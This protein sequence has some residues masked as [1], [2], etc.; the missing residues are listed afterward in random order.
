MASALAGLSEGAALISARDGTVR[1][2]NAALEVLLERPDL[3]GLP[4][5]SLWTLPV[6]LSREESS[7]W[8]GPVEAVCGDG[9]REL[10]AVLIPLGAGTGE[11]GWLALLTDEDSP[12]VDGT[13][14]DRTWETDVARAMARARRS[15]GELSVAIVS[16]D[17]GDTETLEA[18]AIA[19]ASALRAVDAIAHYGPDRVVVIL[20]GCAMD[21]ALEV[22]ARMRAATPA[23]GSSSAGIG[24]WDHEESPASLCA[25]ASEALDRAR[26]QG[27][28]LAV[29]APKPS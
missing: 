25:R 12:G 21:Q 7:A 10:R 8:S 29:F 19:W 11:G 24:Y 14:R 5:A 23:P 1:F 17:Q 15:G 2:V 9:H 20:A 16:L 18:A 4:V 6:D 13:S 27:P 28:G 22:I 3:V 26:Q